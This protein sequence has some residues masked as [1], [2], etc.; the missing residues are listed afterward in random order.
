[1]LLFWYFCLYSSP[2]VCAYACLCTCMSVY[3]WFGYL[4]WSYRNTDTYSIIRMRL[5]IGDR[6]VYT[7][8]DWE[9]WRYFRKSLKSRRPFAV[10][11][12]LLYNT[13][14]HH[15]KE[16]GRLCIVMIS[17]RD[18]RFN[19]VRRILGYQ[20]WPYSVKNGNINTNKQKVISWVFTS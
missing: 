12:G 19:S 20:C 8:I 7:Y 14:W 3:Q 15:M 11:W 5:K 4:V 10:L 2:F 13:A 1:M 17:Y 18:M 9:K 16:M 6:H